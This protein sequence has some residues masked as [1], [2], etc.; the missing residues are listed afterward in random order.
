M[1]A[2]VIPFRRSLSFSSASLGG[3]R[4][5]IFRQQA[6][7]R[8]GGQR[9]VS[10]ILARTGARIGISPDQVAKGISTGSTGYRKSLRRYS[11]ANVRF[12]R[13]VSIARAHG[14]VASIRPT[15]PTA[16]ATAS[17]HASTSD[18]ILLGT[19]GTKPN[20]PRSGAPHPS[21]F[22]IVPTIRVFD[23]GSTHDDSVWISIEVRQT[24]S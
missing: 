21:E 11:G 3:A 12:S 4:L 24:Y 17:P 7:A 1:T 23:T 16:V 9:Q 19:G 22:P 14:P 20:R 10:R 15:S 2:A 8:A 13:G 6:E 5:R 18:R